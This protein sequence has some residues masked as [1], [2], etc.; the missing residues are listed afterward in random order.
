MTTSRHKSLNIHNVN[1]CCI[2]VILHTKIY[3]IRSSHY[4]LLG[5]GTHEMYRHIRYTNT[6]ILTLTCIQWTHSIISISKVQVQLFI[7]KCHHNF[8]SCPCI[9]NSWLQHR[10]IFIFYTW[11]LGVN[12]Q[13]AFYRV[14]LYSSMI[15]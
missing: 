5:C 14:T 2:K 11:S 10:C 9:M 6:Q 8:R 3:N 1:L 7:A 4:P 12:I 15:L 13:G